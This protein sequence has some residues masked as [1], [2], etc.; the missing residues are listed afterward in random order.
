[1]PKPIG[2]GT[3]QASPDTHFFLMEYA[4]MIQYVPTPDAYVAPIAALHLRSMGKSPT[5]KFG[6]PVKTRFGSLTQTN[7][8]ESS[9]EVFWTKLMRRIL[10]TEEKVRGPHGPELSKLLG[11]YFDKVLPRY[12]RPLETGGRSIKPCLLHTDLWPG[13][14]MY[15]ADESSVCVFDASGM[16]GHNERQYPSQYFSGSKS[17]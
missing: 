4:D 9:W 6:F 8:W 10:N 7:D 14:V 12:L 17:F 5:G 3:Y 15:R 13:N 16:W 11:I 2:F 1:M